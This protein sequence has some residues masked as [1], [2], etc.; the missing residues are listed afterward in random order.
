MQ[1]S[2]LTSVFNDD[3]QEIIICDLGKGATDV[4]KGSI[5]QLPSLY[6][7]YHVCSVDAISNDTLTINIDSSES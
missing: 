7:D 2:D 1:V 3:L 5:E 6:D 4:Y